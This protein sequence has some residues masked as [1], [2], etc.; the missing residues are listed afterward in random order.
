MNYS[1]KKYTIHIL[2][3]SAY[4]NAKEPVMDSRELDSAIK[5]KI[6]LKYGQKS[7]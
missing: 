4:Q 7:I 3:M 5:R 2:N 1:Q 6:G